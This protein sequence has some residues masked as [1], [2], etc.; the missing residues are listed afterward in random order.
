MGGGFVKLRRDGCGE[1][2]WIWLRMCR[3]SGMVGRGL[4][5]GRGGLVW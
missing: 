5:K 2:C 4:N 3:M 1:R